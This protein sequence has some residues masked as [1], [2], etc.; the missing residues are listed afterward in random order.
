MSNFNNSKYNYMLEQNKKYMNLTALSFGNKEITY[1]E[2]HESI[3]KYAKLLYKKGVREGD[4]I[5]VCALNVPQ[6]VYLLYALDIIGAIVVGFSPL[7]NKDK[8]RKDIELTRPKMIITVD[9][10]YSDFK[11][12]EKALNFST[13]NY[14][15]ADSITDSKLRISYKALQLL[16]G[17][18]T[19]NKNRNLEMLLQEDLSDIN[20]TP[21]KYAENK[22]T[23]IMFTGGSTGIHKG[24]DLSGDGL[25]SVIEGMKYMYPEDFFTGQTYL[26]NIPLGHMVYGRVI[27]H[28]ALTNNMNYA[29]TLK[30]LPKDFYGELVR[31]NAFAAVGGPPHWASLIEKQGNTYVPRSDLKRGSLSNLHLATSGG[32]A[33]KKVIEDAVNNALS[34][35]GSQVFLGDGLGATELWSV[36]TLSS[37][38]KYKPYSIGSPISTIEIKL[39]DPETGKEVKQG[40][41]GVLNISGP[42]VMIGYHDND[43][44]TEKVISYDE[45]G[46]K[47]CST[48][49]LLRKLEDGSFEYVGRIKRNFVS[50][51]ENIYPEQIEN[52]LSTLPEVNE[53][54]VTS[55]PDES[56]QFMPRY[57]ISLSNESI[58]IANFE[59]KMKLLVEKKLGV[60]W[61]PSSVEYTH[62]PLKR[63]TNSKLDVP[64]YQ[65]KDN[66]DYKDGKISTEEGKRL[67]LKK[68]E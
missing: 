10:K 30:A 21:S 16:K 20:V 24:V 17:N 53:I 50:G 43:E 23:D 58:D 6:S 41:A 40:E 7:D 62:E 61:L 14:S 45:N 1:E 60:N 49:D 29:L 47:W 4:I 34:F 31:T 42:S 33:K 27:M 15:I 18:V 28:I 63:M 26:G 35:A 5:G 54:V 37:G 3:Q 55:I 51:I 19:L 13:M 38:N 65:N 32:E 36:I 64:Y 44:E 9:M 12:N 59:N 56:V 67:R 57:H 25:N 52:L 39:I 11:S 48:G 46:K 22:L 68:C 2:M 8:L 66:E